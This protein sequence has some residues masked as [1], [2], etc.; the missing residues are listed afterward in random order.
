[1]TNRSSHIPMSTA[2]E[3]TV[4]PIGVRSLR[5]G[6]IAMGTT[7]QQTTIAQ[8]KGA[9]SP[10]RRL[11]RTAISAC[12]CPYHAVRCSANVK[13]AQRQDMVMRRRE[14]CEK[15]VGVKNSSK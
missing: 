3:A 7:K 2:T 11:S 13:Y 6:R 9:K 12:S 1:M 10:E 14:R 15:P 4:A 5:N 8:K